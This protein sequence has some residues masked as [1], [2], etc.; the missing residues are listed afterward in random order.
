MRRNGADEN[1]LAGTQRSINPASRSN[2]Y[3]ASPA[4]LARRKSVD[5]SGKPNKSEN[6]HSLL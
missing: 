1:P 2:F 3:A 5:L 6:A 4:P